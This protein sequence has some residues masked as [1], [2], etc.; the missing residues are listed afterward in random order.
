MSEEQKHGT[1]SIS[2]GTIVKIILICLLFVVL[3]L[4]RDIVLIVLTAIVIA[5]AIEP[6]AR[7]LVKWGLPRIFS[8]FLIYVVLGIALAAIVYVFVPLLLQD[9]S[10]F[11]FRA[12]ICRFDFFVGAGGKSGYYK[13]G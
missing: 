11:L 4:I 13:R 6:G 5:S 7:R 2:S 9:A 3:Y 1:I 8:V 10:N 12:S